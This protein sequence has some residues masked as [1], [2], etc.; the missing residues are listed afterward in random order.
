MFFFVLRCNGSFSVRTQVRGLPTKG[1][2]GLGFEVSFGLRVE[3]S[4]FRRATQNGMSVKPK[5][6]H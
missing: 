4:V 3:D 1:G 2:L 6:A 5:L